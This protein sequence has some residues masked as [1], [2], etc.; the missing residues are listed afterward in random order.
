M[1]DKNVKV[2]L[3]Q[4][5]FPEHQVLFAEG[6]FTKF[7]TLY[8]LAYRMP[9]GLGKVFEKMLDGIFVGRFTPRKFLVFLSTAGDKTVRGLKR[10]GRKRLPGI[11]LKL[12]NR[13]YK[14]KETG[15]EKAAA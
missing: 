10:F 6:Y 14:V 1:A 13:K 5:Q 3:I 11:Y 9:K 8:K 2:P 12:R 15:K 4:K 7:V